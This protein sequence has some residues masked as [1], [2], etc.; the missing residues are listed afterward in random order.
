VRTF[1]EQPLPGSWRQRFDQN[2]VGNQTTVAPLLT[3]Q[4][5]ADAVVNPNGTTQYVQRACR[6]GQPVECSVYP[7]ATHQTIPFVAQHEYLPWIA[8]RFAGNKAPSNC[9][10]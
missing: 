3:L 9:S 5:T 8:D 4:G 1:F 10:P 7:G 6:F 2:T